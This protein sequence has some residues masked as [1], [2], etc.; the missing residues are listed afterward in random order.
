MEKNSL[1]NKSQHGFMKTRSCMTQLLETLEEWT[2][3]PDQNFSIDVIHLDFQKAFD[4]IPHQRL[5]SKVHAYGIRGKVY[6]WIRNFLLNRRQRVVLNNSKSTWSEVI[7]GVPQGSVLGPILFILY[8][9]DLP[10]II[11][12]VSK[13][14]A[15]DTKLYRSVDSYDDSNTIQM[16]LYELDNWSSSWQ[17]EFNI[18]KCKVLHLGKKNP[19]NFY[20]MFD[21]EN[22]CLSTIKD[23]KEQRDLGVLWMS[24]ANL[25][26]KL[27]MLCKKQMEYW[28]LSEELLNT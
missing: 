1:F 24:H 18:P 10:D 14:F 2:D 8:I 16:D 19:R 12:C 5:L 17:M 13:L 3:L 28:H 25:K 15:D 22:K 4:T 21:N 7:S 27:A 11:S 20:L 9:N 23:I 6:E 26:N